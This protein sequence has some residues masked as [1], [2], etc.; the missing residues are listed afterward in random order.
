MISLELPA[1]DKLLYRLSYGGKYEISITQWSKLENSPNSVA[2]A[3]SQ[4]CDIFELTDSAELKCLHR[5][6]G[7]TRVITDLDWCPLQANLLAT[8][9]FDSYVNIWDIR[10]PRGVSN[11]KPQFSLSAL[12]G[13]SQ[14]KWS[15]FD[16]DILASCDGG[17][18][19][20]WDLRRPN[21]PTEYI[22]AHASKINGKKLIN[23]NKLYN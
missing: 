6:K 11:E 5:L 22:A 14:V 18:V 7:H 21:Q 13:A 20:I 23:K 1:T 15:K 12:D 10:N 8:C 2:I 3:S 9:S 16:Q 4:R 19:K 17:H